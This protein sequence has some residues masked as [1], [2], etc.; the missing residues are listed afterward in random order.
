MTYKFDLKARDITP[1]KLSFESY[2]WSELTALLEFVVGDDQ[3]LN[4]SLPVITV[5]DKG[6][7]IVS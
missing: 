2:I 5:C 6:E 4:Q 3:V 1:L 7:N